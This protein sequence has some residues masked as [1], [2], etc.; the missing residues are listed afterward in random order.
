MYEL[1]V[2]FIHSIEKTKSDGKR[3]TS[4]VIHMAAN[5]AN[6]ARNK[7]FRN[8]YHSYAG[9]P[10]TSDGIFREG[11]KVIFMAD[12]SGHGFIL[13]AISRNPGTERKIDLDP[14]LDT[15]STFLEN[16]DN[17]EIPIT[18]SDW[19]QKKMDGWIAIL[20]SGLVWLRS[21]KNL[22]IIMNPVL[23]MMELL[24]S[25]FSIKV[26]PDGL[27]YGSLNFDI[28]KR[29]G[30]ANFSVVMTS[31]TTGLDS[32]GTLSYF[33]MGQHEENPLKRA[34]FVLAK[35]IAGPPQ[36]NK[37]LDV[38]SYADGSVSIDCQNGV[39]NLNIDL[40]G[41]V[42]LK[43]TSLDININE[44]AKLKLNTDGSSSL[45]TTGLSLGNDAATEPFILG[46]KFA[47]N[48][49]DLLNLLANHTHAVAEAVATSSPTLTALST[50]SLKQGI[51]LSAKH[52]LD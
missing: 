24:A 44:T 37:I 35:N 22:E 25:K 26:G 32:T 39:L 9:D 1:Y 50:K 31:D 20:Y 30:K 13:S 12:E 3:I 47:S 16:I 40:L 29:T 6:S 33:K 14:N 52:K 11:T 38:S 21:K 42:S 28:N 4:Y 5:S 17:G 48:Y 49:R 36:T 51:E 10:D 45:K 2:G 27:Q 15:S 43:A 8:I 18:E 7:V 19:I 23:N 34:S 41:N 46:N